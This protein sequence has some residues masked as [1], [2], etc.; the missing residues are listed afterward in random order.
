MTIELRPVPRED[1]R[2]WLEAIESAS[3]SGVS[4][5]Y[6]QLIERTIEL[7][8]TI[9]AFDGGRLVG[10]GAAFSFEMTVPG[11]RSVRAAGVTNVGVMPTHRRRGILRQMMA[12]QLADVRSRGEPVAILWA[13]EGSIYQ[14]F[15]YG[16]ATLAGTIDVARD[17]TVFRVPSPDPPGA[18]RLVDRDEAA[19]LL[20]PIY[21]VVRVA[22]PGFLQRSDDWW[23]NEVLSDPAFARRGHDRKFFAVHER[24]GTPVAY[25]IYRVRQEWGDLGPLSQLTVTEL[26]AIDADARREMWRFVF[27]VDL[28]AHIKNR[29]GPPDEPLLLMVAEPRKLDLRLRDGLWLRVVDVPAA[30]EQR[31]YAADGSAVLEIH[32]EFM[33]GAAGRFRIETADG[34]ARVTRTDE[35]A[36]LELD[37]A[38]L[39]AVYLGAFTFAQLGRAGRTRELIPGA[40]ARVDALFATSVAPWSAQIF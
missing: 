21:D 19:H 33:P 7:E 16:L 24:A 26:I 6:L 27:G 18:V 29:V 38:D 31:G 30:L 15:G 13:S 40:R 1:L 36:D 34:S 4:D 10:G 11:G 20:P 25:V 22:T 12:H 8:R 14:R 23:S 2:R 17:R 3:S 28:I 35:P 32:D 39:A 9:G 5:E 37:A